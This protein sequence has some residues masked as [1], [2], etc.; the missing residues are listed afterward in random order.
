MAARRVRPIRVEGNLAYITLTRGYEAVID[1]ADVPLVDR[2]NWCAAVTPRSVYAKRKGERDGEP[3]TIYLHRAILAVPADLEAD[4]INC[5]GL[6]NRRV[7]LRQA[8]P[9]Q[10]SRNSRRPRVNSSGLKGVSWS[11]RDRKWQAHINVNGVGQA[12]GQFDTATAAHAA[13]CRAAI[14]HHGDFARLE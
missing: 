9:A 11:K 8:T 2:W 6:D 4:H 3:A 13:Y 12:L 1:A 7:N 5:D 14:R 10:N